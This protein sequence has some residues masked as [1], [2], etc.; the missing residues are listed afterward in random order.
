MDKTYCV[1]GKLFNE[2]IKYAD[3]AT[4]WR[5]RHYKRN[6]IPLGELKTKL[7]EAKSCNDNEIKNVLK[8]FQ[9]GK[10]KN[11]EPLYTSEF[12]YV[13]NTGKIYFI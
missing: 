9:N 2:F 10:D 5:F 1:P 3:I 4:D 13:Q 7:P 12:I 6:D 8:I 11:G